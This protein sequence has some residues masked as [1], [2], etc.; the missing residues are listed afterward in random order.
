MHPLHGVGDE[1]RTL[2]GRL[3]PE[4][5]SE[6]RET[7]PKRVSDDPRQVNFR[8]KKFVFDEKF[9]RR[10]T[11]LAFSEQFLRLD[12]PTDLKIKFL[13]T[14]CFRCTHSQLC[15]TKK[16]PKRVRLRRQDLGGV[17]V[18]EGTSI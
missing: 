11:F 12:P 6:W 5:G 15:T 16:R 9:W 7:L 2:S 13:A 1:I 18:L 14:F 3:P 17:R 8:P 4:D 10:T